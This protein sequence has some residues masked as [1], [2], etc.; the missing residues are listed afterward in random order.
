M[1]HGKN[2][3]LIE[4]INEILNDK[5]IFLIYKLNLYLFSEVRMV[6]RVLLLKIVILYIK[7][8]KIKL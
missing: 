1:F 4:E 7:Y 8:I 5:N 6:R 2:E 3:Q